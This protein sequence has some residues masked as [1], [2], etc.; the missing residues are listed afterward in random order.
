MVIQENYE[1]LSG[2]NNFELKSKYLCARFFGGDQRFNIMRPVGRK[3]ENCFI[4][5]STKF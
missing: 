5:K 3:S 1:D 2:E 4:L